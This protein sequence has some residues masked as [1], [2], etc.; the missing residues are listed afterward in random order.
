MRFINFIYHETG[1]KKKKIG[2]HLRSGK[3]TWNS[4]NRLR[5]IV[6][7]FLKQI[8]TDDTKWISESKPKRRKT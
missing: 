5:I 3:K 2:F 8:V 7:C 1:T 6:S 4:Q